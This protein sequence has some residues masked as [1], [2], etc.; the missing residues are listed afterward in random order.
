MVIEASDQGTRRKWASTCRFFN[1]FATKLLW[2]SLSINYIQLET[3]ANYITWTDWH[4]SS[5]ESLITTPIPLPYPTLASNTSDNRL[6]KSLERDHGIVRFLVQDGHRASVT[7]TTN[8]EGTGR[9][10]PYIEGKLAAPPGSLIQEL[11]LDLREKHNVIRQLP[12]DVTLP[13]LLSRIPNAKYCT[14]EGA[15]YD[16]YLR[17]LSRLRSLKSLKMRQ[18]DQYYKRACYVDL[19]LE[20]LVPIEWKEL[21]VNFGYL[22]PMASLQALKIGRLVEG[23]GV[24]LAQAIRGLNLSHLDVSASSF[25]V[26]TDDNEYEDRSNI[27][28]TKNSPSPLITFIKEVSRGFLED[29]KGSFPPSLKTLVL[30]DRYH[31]TVPME[32]NL[33]GTVSERS[34]LDSFTVV[35]PIVTP[36]DNIR[37][38]LGLDC[39]YVIKTDDN[40]YLFQVKAG[41][42]LPCECEQELPV[43]VMHCVKMPFKPKVKDEITN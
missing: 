5:R 24:S 37:T 7:P 16:M 10:F 6:A 33:L 11:R 12:I 30:R 38:R 9:G 20:K 1:L 34:S 4:L 18:A 3:Y 36:I 19:L 41:M 14:I 2:Q 21:V 8:K 26:P 32:K 15:I 43:N 29:D 22:E 28:G 13:L 35:F 31:A 42:G 17:E 39:M 23:E 27:E 25:T 40:Q